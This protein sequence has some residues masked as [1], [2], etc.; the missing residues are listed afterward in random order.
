MGISSKKSKGRVTFR[1]QRKDAKDRLSLRFFFTFI[2]SK[3]DL[4]KIYFLS[5]NVKEV[6]PFLKYS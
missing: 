3:F 4:A 6:G 5:R 2:Y 1:D